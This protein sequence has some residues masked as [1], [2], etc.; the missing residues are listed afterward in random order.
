M[1]DADELV[2]PLLQV[3]ANADLANNKNVA[4][5]SNVC[6]NIFQDESK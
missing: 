2:N 3:I 4:M 1:V 6:A 5:Q